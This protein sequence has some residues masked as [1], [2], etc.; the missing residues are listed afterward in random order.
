MK[1][2]EM[3]QIL[4][5][6]IFFSL[7]N[8]SCN[9]NRISVV[10][11]SLQLAG[12]N[13]S[14]IEKVLE[15]YKNESEDRLKYRAAEFLIKNMKYKGYKEPLH[16]YEIVFDSVKN[17]T[18]IS[19]KRETL[20][21]MMDSISIEERKTYSKFHYDLREITADYLIE[22]IELAFKAWNMVPLKKRASF[23]DFCNY[24]LP[25]RSLN[26]PLEK[27]SRKHLHN[28]YFWVSDLFHKDYDLVSIVDTVLSSFNFEGGNRFT[29]FYNLP[30]SISQIENGTVGRCDD[31]VNYLVNVFR[32]IGLVA[33]KDYIIQWGNNNRSGHSWTFIK[34][35]KEEYSTGFKGQNLKEIYSEGSIPKVYRINFDWGEKYKNFINL[36]VTNEYVKTIDL[37][38]NN[39]F[40][41]PKKN[42]VLCVFNVYK[43]WR[44]V[45]LGEVDLNGQFLFEDTGIDV[46]YMVGSLAGSGL[47]SANYPFYIDKKSEINFFR[48]NLIERDS[49]AITRKYGLSSPVHRKRI[50]WIK[51]LEGCYFE[52]SNDPE[53]KNSTVLHVIENHNTTHSK[54][55]QTESKASFRYV[56]FNTNENESFLAKLRFYDTLKNELKGKVMRKGDFDPLW[57]NGAFDDNQLTC[58]GG[59]N[60]TLGLEFDS[61]KS[62]GYIEFQSR[63]DDNH[64][65]IG[66]EYEL[67]Y[68]NKKWISLGRQIAEDTILHYKVPKNSLLWL[69]N[70]TKGIEEHVFTVGDDNRQKWLG[71]D[72]YYHF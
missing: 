38:V 63:N 48:P 24:I 66:E 15:Y 17:L 55:I 47:K 67:Y 23:D 70:L 2:K 72:N 1:N 19:K 31:G 11:E 44:E 3:K 56:R 28:K 13:R 57:K 22:N 40:H 53:F 8:F 34:Y 27:N 26:E 60:I 61:P 37:K 32:S 21:R 64:I 10:E 43:N 69:R 16:E 49:V 59:A 6:L 39:I 7:A 36:D 12:K 18:N 4:I 5:G 14:E 50:N 54:T 62:L 51:S 41:A 33:S 46:L 20:L 9:D 30:L 58:E 52:A 45:S 29:E 25:Y 65:N 71:F 68:W 35:G 42:P